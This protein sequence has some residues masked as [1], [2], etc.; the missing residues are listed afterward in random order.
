[1]ATIPETTL[2]WLAALIDG[3]G[4]VMLSKRVYAASAKNRFKNHHYR[5]VV[6]VYNTDLRLLEAIVEKTGID[7]IYNHKL[8]EKMNHKKEAYSWRMGANDIRIW[9]PLL[10]PWLIIKRAQMELLLEALAIAETNTPRKGEKWTP[11]GTERRD[12]IVQSI[13]QLNRKGRLI[14]TVE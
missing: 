1:M 4:S 7:R 9:G 6:V 11:V 3:E 12:E 14:G 2:A 10:L 13:S 8:P 5:A